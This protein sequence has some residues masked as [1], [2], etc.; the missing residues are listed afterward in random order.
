M[1][2]LEENKTHSLAGFIAAA[3]ILQSDDIAYPFQTNLL[4]GRPRIM[5]MLCMVLCEIKFESKE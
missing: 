5:L 4:E 2:S 1:Y 3:T